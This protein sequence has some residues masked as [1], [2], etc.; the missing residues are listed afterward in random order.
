MERETGSH[1]P[2][3]AATP[4]HGYTVYPVDDG[5]VVITGPCPGGPA[6]SCRKA[7]IVLSDEAL[8]IILGIT[9][10]SRDGDNFI[11]DVT[12][13]QPFLLELDAASANSAETAFPVLQS[14]EAFIEGLAEQ[15][16]FLFSWEYDVSSGPE[17]SEGVCGAAST[18]L[19]SLW[20]IQ[21]ASDPHVLSRLRR[22]LRNTGPSDLGHAPQGASGGEPRANR[23]VAGARPSSCF[24][25][26]FLRLL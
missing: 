11:K 3:D 12:E 4:A 15:Y 23:P 5:E 9:L 22:R 20:L 7:G 19:H 24:R 21:Q 16:D 17:E 14:V 8:E 1:L 10:S 13:G 25:G 18:S 6:H 2:A 26:P